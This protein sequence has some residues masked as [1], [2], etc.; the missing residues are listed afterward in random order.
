M[1]SLSGRFG[2]PP[3]SGCPGG[4]GRRSQPHEAVLQ[5]H[6]AQAAPGAAGGDPALH[7]PHLRR[8][9][10]PLGVDARGTVQ[11]LAPLGDLGLHDGHPKQLPRHRR[12][13][14]ALPLP[15]SDDS[16]CCRPADAQKVGLM[17]EIA[18]RSRKVSEKRKGR[19]E[20][21]DRLVSRVFRIYIPVLLFI[22][23]TLFPFYWMF[24]TSLKSDTELLDFH[25]L[26]IFV[27]EPTL[28]NYQDLFTHTF[29]PRWA[30]NTAIVPV[31]SLP[32]LFFCATFPASSWR[33]P[34]FPGPTLIRWASFLSY[35]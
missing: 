15:G 4:R 34:P 7:D 14:L 20:I 22:F 12:R 30:L 5:H 16:D 31:S 10:A 24:I 3:R 18:R 33:R 29:F 8:F 32:T 13:H 26:P 9:P 11:Q 19:V 27:R 25:Q 35:P 17:A 23:I 21:G 1:A 2:G 28:K 6:A